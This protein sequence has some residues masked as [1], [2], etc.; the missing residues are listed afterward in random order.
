M[1]DIVNNYTSNAFIYVCV[2]VCGC[3]CVCRFEG[4]GKGT[5]LNFPPLFSLGPAYLVDI[6]TPVS[7]SLFFDI[8]E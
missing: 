6:N 5:D 1:I 7:S 4:K 8:I 2:R 3:E